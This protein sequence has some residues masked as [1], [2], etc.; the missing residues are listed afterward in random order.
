MVGLWRN[1]Q[2]WITRRRPGGISV[3]VRL[4]Q[5]VGVEAA[6]VAGVAGA[7]DLVHE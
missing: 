2:L 7:T 4:Q 1:T 3:V 5:H 6:V